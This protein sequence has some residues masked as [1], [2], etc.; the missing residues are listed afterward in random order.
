MKFID[1]DIAYFRSQAELFRG[2]ASGARTGQARAEFLA[3][4]EAIEKFIA[5]VLNEGMVKL[6]GEPDD[7][8]DEAGG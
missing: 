6:T 2:R 4:A 1:L 3:V 5:D 7:I 8:A